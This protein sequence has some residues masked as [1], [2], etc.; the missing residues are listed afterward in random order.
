M[1]MIQVIFK[2]IGMFCVWSLL[3]IFFMYIYRAIRVGFFLLKEK[4]NKQK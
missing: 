2:I 4:F 3:I 1:K